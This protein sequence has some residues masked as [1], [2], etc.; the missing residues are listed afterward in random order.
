MMDGPA[1][2]VLGLSEWV[3]D[4]CSCDSSRAR[5]VFTLFWVLWGTC[6][7]EEELLVAVGRAETLVPSLAMPTSEHCSS[8]WS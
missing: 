1:A 2:V 6:S 7:L 8:A 3:T 4:G 5:N